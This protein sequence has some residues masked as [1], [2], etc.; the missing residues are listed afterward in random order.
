MKNLKQV[1]IIGI[2][3]LHAVV[4]FAQHGG[5]ILYDNSNRY[6][7]NSNY[8]S[9]IGKFSPTGNKSTALQ[10]ND[11][12]LF[13]NVNAIM[14]VKADS[15][16]AIFNMIQMGETAVEVDQLINER[17][18]KFRDEIMAEG[19]N[20]VHFFLDMVSLIPVYEYEIEK[21][22]F[23]KT[24]N[25]VPK[26]FELQKNIHIK[27]V[28]AEM[29]DKI[30]T[31][32]AKN[33][34][35]DLIKVEYFVNNT[36]EIFDTLR[37]RAVEVL[38]KKIESFKKINVNLDTVFHVFAENRSVAFPVDRYKSYQ[39]YSSASLEAAKSNAKVT[40]IKKHNTMF[41]NKIPYHQYDIVIN[42]EITEPVVQYSYN[43]KVKYLIKRPV[44]K[45]TEIEKEI[46]MIT[47]EG[48]IKS[49]K[50]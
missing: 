7:Q 35:Y 29:F 9:Q 46:I 21:K 45:K 44:I 6:N 23:S 50:Y 12:E 32:A 31:I 39:A 10:I 27:Y 16:L 8:N 42:S 33:E 22:L 41:Y 2:L 11:K 15:Y 3:F 38:N 19:I 48:N 13:L 34:I 36:E 40:H 25:E 49:I 1:L 37:Y 28:D 18:K 20:N 14:N 47:P 43:L 17:Y 26:G 4:L 24:Y 30:L 5:N